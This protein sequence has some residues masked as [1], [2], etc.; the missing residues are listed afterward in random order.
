LAYSSW[1][2]GATTFTG[3]PIER[4]F[5]L[6]RLFAEIV[7]VDQCDLEI[8]F[9]E[10]NKIA[11]FHRALP[12]GGLNP[13]E[14]PPGPRPDPWAPARGPHKPVEWIRAGDPIPGLVPGRVRTTKGG[15]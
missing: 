5:E 6:F 11:E 15:R 1:L 9:R 3:R 2:V 4:A 12:N 14:P 13:L 7:G 10:F 8:A